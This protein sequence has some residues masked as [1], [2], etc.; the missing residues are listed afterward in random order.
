MSLGVRRGYHTLVIH[1]GARTL[2]IGRACDIVPVTVEH[3][4]ARRKRRP[5]EKL[6]V[7][8]EDKM[9]VDQEGPELRTCVRR[10]GIVDDPDKFKPALDGVA[11]ALRERMRFYKLRISSSALAQCQT[12]NSDENNEPEI[13]HD[14]NDPGRIDW[15]P[16]VKSSP[17]VAVG[18]DVWRAGDSDEWVVRWPLTRG[19]NAAAYPSGSL[20]EVLGD[21][22][23]IWS[24]VLKERL[25]IHPKD[26]PL[27]SVV[28]V[29][30][31]LPER[32]YVSSLIRLLLVN[33]S[34]KQLAVQQESL[35]A[36]YGAG[37]SSALVV[38]V[39]AATTSIACVDE[40]WV[41]PDT[42]MSLDVGGDD[43]TELFVRLLARAGSPWALDADLSR[44]DDFATAEALKSSL[45]S[46]AE[47]HV[48]LNPT[49]FVSR[50]FGAPA[51]K[52]R[53]KTYDEPVLA[54]MVIFEPQAI[55]YDAKRAAPQPVQDG[56]A[57]DIGEQPGEGIT[58]AMVFSTQHLSA[59]GLD[60]P[61]EAAKLPLDVAVFNSAR[62][63]G[64]EDKVRKMLSSVLLVGGGA[65]RIHG[66]NAALETR[67]SAIAS[68]RVPGM[69]TQRV[70]V[71]SPA[72]DVDA[73]VLCWKGGSVLARMDSVVEFWVS[74]EE[75]VRQHSFAFDTG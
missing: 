28:L 17:D 30:P 16:R 31:D 11:H 49:E 51:A 20:Q 4:V 62:A 23:T 7:Q 72:K 26:Y 10:R 3:A 1:P 39:G 55:D 18:D 59:L 2:R 12:F 13:I 54:A 5:K 9:N 43:I 71:V 57:E 42:R 46:L 19:F 67:L 45:A 64:P 24:E 75:W 60:V 34:F 53:A 27:Y 15:L 38:D 8:A 68:G 35:A 65:A 58:Q 61:R 52:Y 70:V 74:R 14:H 56:V 32:G 22:E 37:L 29:I 33:M 69:D 40:G 63:V 73:R 41:V 66:V 21:L 50:R 48:A 36:T 47:E 44:V 25:S 6:T